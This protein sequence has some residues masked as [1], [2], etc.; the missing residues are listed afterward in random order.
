M[1]LRVLLPGEV[2][3][4]EAVSGVAADGPQGQFCLLPRHVDYVSGLLPGIL[5]YVAEHGGEFFLAVNGG[6][7][8]KQGPQVMVTTRQAV[9]GT[10]GELEARVRVMLGEVDEKERAARAA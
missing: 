3:V 2:L 8:V 5:S 6:L 10:L 1:R 7:L 9:P 4:D